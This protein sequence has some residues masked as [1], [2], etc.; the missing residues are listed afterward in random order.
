[1]G[2]CVVRTARI[3]FAARREACRDCATIMASATAAS[4]ANAARAPRARGSRGFAGDTLIPFR[5]DHMLRG[6]T[7]KLLHESARITRA[8]RVFDH[9]EFFGGDASGEIKGRLRSTAQGI[10]VP[11][12]PAGAGAADGAPG[13]F[14]RG[15]GCAQ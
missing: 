13:F 10:L 3:S 14:E 5:R 7:A 2:A 4:A 12:Q 8:L 1:M 6:H 11:A 9:V 15:A